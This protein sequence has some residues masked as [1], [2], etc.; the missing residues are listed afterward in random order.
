[1]ASF[2]KIVVIIAIILLIVC[3][4]FIGIALT[5]SGSASQW[6]PIVGSCPDYW[7]DTSGNGS[8][9][10]NVQ[11]LGTC[12][13]GGNGVVPINMPNAKIAMNFNVAPYVGSAGTCA[14]YQWATKCGV[15]W[16]GITSGVVN[17]CDA[18]SSAKSSL[19]AAS[20][21]SAP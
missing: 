21:V 19:T 20:S 11:N 10:V 5:K 16:D 4:V 3:L 9:C 8:N 13:S 6:P 14:K 15:T 18:I 1:M 2:Q 17:P 12:S 7:Y